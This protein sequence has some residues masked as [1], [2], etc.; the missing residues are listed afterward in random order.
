[1]KEQLLKVMQ[2]NQILDIVYM[3]KDQTITRRRI[4]LIKIVGEQVQAYCF[5]RNA[6]RNFIIENILAAHP[7]NRK[8]RALNA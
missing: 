2:H 3:A 8:T 1:M 5:T 4:K 6:K 7:V